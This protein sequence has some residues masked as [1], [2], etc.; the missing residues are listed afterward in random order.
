MKA[1]A[2]KS[3][4]NDTLT[5]NRQGTNHQHTPVKKSVSMFPGSVPLIQRKSICPCDGGCPRCTNGGEIQPKL[6]IGQPNDKYEQEADR[7]TERVMRIL[8]PQT[9]KSGAVPIPKQQSKIQE[10]SP[11]NAIQR[12]AEHGED[13][14]KDRGPAS[15]ESPHPSLP[16]LIY[17]CAEVHR[18]GT[19]ERVRC[20]R[21]AVGYAQR[22]LNQWYGKS[23]LNVDCWFGTKTD[24]AT[25]HF[26]ASVK[27]LNDDGKIGEDTWPAL[28]SAVIGPQPKVPPSAKK[29][30]YAKPPSSR[31]PPEYHVPPYP[32][33]VP[34]VTPPHFPRCPPGT[35]PG[36]CDSRIDVR[37]TSI[38]DVPGLFRHAFIIHH[39]GTTGEEFAYRGG[40]TKGKSVCPGVGLQ[41]TWKCPFNNPLLRAIGVGPLKEKFQPGATDWP[42]L[43]SRILLEGSTADTKDG[44][45][46]KE[47]SRIS[48]LCVPYS[49]CG[50]NS[51]SVAFTLL[52]NCGITA[53][54]PPDFSI[55]PGWGMLI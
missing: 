44:C 54:A 32:A 53:M 48:A 19:S 27:G 17:S 6:T 24:Q 28:E 25:K 41:P 46:R 13:Q 52:K 26:Q 3:L 22:L 21:P 38:T 45:F 12:Q 51:N 14:C 55:Y 36:P 43:S 34:G 9:S 47:A 8:N 42:A 10:L 16:P 50:P 11:G 40:N 7:A 37:G 5:R 15:R 18:L 33:P 35:S 1:V 20:K 31:Q 23:E 49:P 2:V 4:S 29:P 30:P 39:D